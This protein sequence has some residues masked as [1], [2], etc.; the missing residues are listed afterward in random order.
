MT[1]TADSTWYLQR[2]PGFWTR[3][4]QAYLDLPP[5]V[6]LGR[7]A[8]PTHEAEAREHLLEVLLTFPVGGSRTQRLQRRGG[9]PTL[10]DCAEE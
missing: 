3:K 4:R 8:S 6:G 1:W 5:W 2:A 10:R 9:R 7:D